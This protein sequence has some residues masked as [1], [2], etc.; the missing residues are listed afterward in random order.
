VGTGRNLTLRFAPGAGSVPALRTRSNI[1]FTMAAPANGT[2]ISAAVVPNTGTANARTSASAT[3]TGG[4]AI[5][6]IA[7]PIAGGTTGATA[8]TP[9][10]MDVV[11]TAG[12][13]PNVDVRTRLE[14]Y[15]E[16][17]V[18]SGV[19]QVPVTR[20]CTAGN[21]AAGQPN[22]VLTRTHII[23]TTPPT[24]TIT[25]PAANQAV[26]VG[27]AVPAAFSCADAIQLA[28]CVG[29]TPNGSAINTSTPGVKTL[30]VT[31]TD[32]AGNTAQRLVS[33]RVVNVVLPIRFESSQLALVDGAAAYFNTDRVGLARLATLTVLYY[34]A[35]QG[36][37]DTPYTPP[38]NTGSVTINVTYTVAEA[39]A[40]AATAAAVGLTPEQFQ[41][42]SVN[43]ALY[44]YAVRN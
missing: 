5:L 15:R 17:D 9:P 1:V 10:A 22:P 32:Q 33:L 27:A 12:T 38:A 35:V 16:T 6:T 36:P 40:I 23:D 11:I 2:A 42:F 7:G 25:G 24:V 34:I 44:V 20:T 19:G 37:P 29:T 28:S 41:R 3:V 4:K 8:Y 13:T 14:Q 18:V 39:Q 26:A 30:V 31:A 21:E 43:I